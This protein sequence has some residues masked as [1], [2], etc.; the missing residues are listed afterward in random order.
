[1]VLRQGLQNKYSY[2]YR[3]ATCMQKDHFTL[4][5]NG[6]DAFLFKPNYSWVYL[7]SS[8]RNSSSNIRSNLSLRQ[9]NAIIYHVYIS[10][11]KNKHFPHKT[12]S[13]SF[14]DLPIL[15]TLVPVT[16]TSLRH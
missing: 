5:Q 9:I 4:K 8:T 3:K 7:C 1:M 6:E 2:V 16:V 13:R 10:N 14:S 12:D 11:N 15:F